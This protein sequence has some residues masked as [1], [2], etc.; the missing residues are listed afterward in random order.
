VDTP[1]EPT[2]TPPTFAERVNSF[3]DSGVSDPATDT[4]ETKEV[5]QPAETVVEAES[6]ETDASEV[7]DAVTDEGET[8]TD[9]DEESF[10]LSTKEGGVQTVKLSELRNGYLRQSDYTKKT[11]ALAEERKAI[12]AAK[13]ESIGKLQ[14][15]KQ[16]EADLSQMLMADFANVDWDQ[17]RQQD[18]IEYSMLKE[19]KE[20][21]EKSIAEIK[22]KSDQMIAQVTQEESAKLADALGWYD[23][24]KRDSDIALIQGYVNEIGIPAEAFSAVNNHKIMTALREAALY[25][26]LQDKK[27]D[28]VKKVREAPK[29]NAKP[30]KAPQIEVKK[31]GA[32]L[33]YN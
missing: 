12:E 28:I 21:R 10:E 29:S 14:T 4:T 1:S 7:D 16:I 3:Y 22:A 23:T 9:D 25:R 20:N 18:Y 15:L 2:S 31:T 24:T 30:V 5:E 11:T 32:D 8:E 6:D 17:L 13:T 33:M 27:P 19:S 26:K